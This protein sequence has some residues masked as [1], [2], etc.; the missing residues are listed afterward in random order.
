MVCSGD[1]SFQISSK[2]LVTENKF[3]MIYI[4]VNSRDSNEYF[5]YLS[6]LEAGVVWIHNCRVASKTVAPASK[7]GREKVLAIPNRGRPIMALYLRSR[8][9]NGRSRLIRG[10]EV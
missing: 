6:F 7:C 4:K 3:R 8:V 2:V 5:L 9:S 1:R 10:R